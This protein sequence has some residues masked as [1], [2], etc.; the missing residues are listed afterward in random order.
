M[1]EASSQLLVCPS[2]WY[3]HDLVV[4]SARE[5]IL[6]FFLKKK[7]YWI[8]VIQKGKIK[9]PTFFPPYTKTP[10]PCYNLDWISSTISLSPGIPNICTNLASDGD[11]MHSYLKTSWTSYLVINYS[12]E[13]T[14]GKQEKWYSEKKNHIIFHAQEKERQQTAI[15]TGAKRL[16]N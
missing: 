13:I 15:A 14:L 1:G 11:L 10:I 6:L 12:L 9:S 8:L 4:L 7:I 3:L 2:R 16:K 5:V